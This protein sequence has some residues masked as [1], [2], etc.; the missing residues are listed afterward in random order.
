MVVV[1][2]KYG[3]SGSGIIRFAVVHSQSGEQCELKRF[4][5]RVLAGVGVLG[6]LAG[7]L[8]E[9]SSNSQTKGRGSSSLG[10]N[11]VYNKL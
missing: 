5:H 11:C 8:G 9:N 7:T 6:K 10:Y 2:W 3:A 1:A 4:E